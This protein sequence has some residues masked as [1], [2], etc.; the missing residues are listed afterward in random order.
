MTTTEPADAG[1]NWKGVKL[2]MARQIKA[3][4]EVFLQ[5]Q[6]QSAIA[7]DQ[8]AT[9]MAGIC[10]TLA[11]A[12]V[13]GGIAYWD[14]AQAGPVLAASFGAALMLIIAAGFAGWSARPVDFFFPGNQPSKWYEIRDA[15]LAYALGGEAE[16]YE[17]HIQVNQAI[18]TA[19]HHAVYV[20]FWFALASPA[21]G[22]LVWV[23]AKIISSSC[24]G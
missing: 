17:T 8:R 23:T 20:G 7:S 22:A 9:T 15:D 10:V 14:K 11:T 13:A 21:V 3:Q 12:V 1:V 4:G 6:L 5:A 19:N 16:N 24:L 18:L 2:E